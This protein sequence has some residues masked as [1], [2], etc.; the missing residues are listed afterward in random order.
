MNLVRAGSGWRVP[1][2]VLN[3]CSFTPT[4]QMFWVRD[5]LKRE[6]IIYRVGQ[7]V[8]KWGAQRG[9][10][11]MSTSQAAARG[12]KALPLRNSVAQGGALQH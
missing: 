6:R 8:K 11:Q 1:G 12:A 2:K 7:V 4:E 9:R 10:L 5:N 3:D